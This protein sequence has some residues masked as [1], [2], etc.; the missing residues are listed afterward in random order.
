MQLC[1]VYGSRR[2]QCVIFLHQVMNFLQGQEWGLMLLDGKIVYELRDA[3][4]YPNALSRRL[5]HG[6]LKVRL[7]ENSRGALGLILFLWFMTYDEMQH[8]L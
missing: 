2:V 3:F 4:S 1:T 8:F 6:C 5:C 7:R